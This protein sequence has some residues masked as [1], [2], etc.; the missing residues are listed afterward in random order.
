[1]DMRKI[2]VISDSK[3]METLLKPFCSECTVAG[4][5]R[6]AVAV[7]Q[8]ALDEYDIAFIDLSLNTWREDL[9][10]LRQKLPV[11]GFSGSDMKA[12]VEAMQ[13]G[14]SD[15]IEKTLTRKSLE[16]IIAKHKKKF[17]PHSEGF[18][19]IVGKSSLM[20]EV[21]GLIKKAAVSESNVLITGES[22]TGKEPVARS[23]HRWSPRSQNAFMTINCSAIPDTLLESELFGFEK[24]AFTGANYTK[25]GI[26]E[27]GDGGTVFLDEIGDVS[28]LFQTKV[29]RVIQEGEFMRVGGGRHMHVDARFIAATNRELRTLCKKGTFREDL[30]YRLNV[31][32]IHLPTLR[33]RMEDI[34][35]LVRHFIRKYAAKRKDIAIRDITDETM[36][37]LMNYPY[38][39][40]VRELENIIEHAISFTTGPEI[41]PSSLPQFLQQTTPKKRTSTPKMRDAVSAY[42]RELIWQALQ[43]A[44]GNIS[45][46][47]QIL[48][49]YRQQLQRKIKQ[50][51][52]AT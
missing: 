35:L 23:I 52:I 33:Q 29:L 12:A 1:V 22:G 45:K 41:L 13:L 36:G 42:E 24:G 14:A 11:I 3:D 51:R 15:V 44:R 26:L 9:L 43:E 47:S 48:G 39:G 7:D 50:L 21:F 31:I 49:I 25:K 5:R 10:V 32:N 40:N 18:D 4:H 27:L 34:P 38:P 8:S 17:L 16:Q 6:R 20:Q 2:L 28:P 46:A 19:Q 30:Y 37:I